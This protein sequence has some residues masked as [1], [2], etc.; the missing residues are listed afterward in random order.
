[1]KSKNREKFERMYG[2]PLKIVY[3][4]MKY[5]NNSEYKYL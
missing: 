2:F 3:D 4:F 5:E 1:M